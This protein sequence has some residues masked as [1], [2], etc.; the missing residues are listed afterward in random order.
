MAL[1]RIGVI[2]EL[3]VTSQPTDGDGG[4]GVQRHYHEV[5]EH[6]S[7]AQDIQ[8]TGVVCDPAGLSARIGR[9]YLSTYVF[10]ALAPGEVANLTKAATCK[11][12]FEIELFAFSNPSC[13]NDPRVGHDPSCR[14]RS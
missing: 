4:R 14:S 9:D 11:A 8:L 12:V 13:A 7:V 5:T 3:V 1:L 2:V 10:A 6:E